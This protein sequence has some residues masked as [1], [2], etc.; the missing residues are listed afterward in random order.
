MHPQDL[1]AQ[2]HLVLI[3][4]LF[5]VGGPQ[6]LVHF[7]GPRCKQSCVRVSQRAAGRAHPQR[8]CRTTPT[9]RHGACW[10]ESVVSTLSISVMCSAS[11]RGAW[12]RER[13]IM[14]SSERLVPVHTRRRRR[15]EPALQEW[16]WEE[17][18]WPRRSPPFLQRKAQ[19]REAPWWPCDT[20]QQRHWDGRGRLALRGQ[21]EHRESCYCRPCEE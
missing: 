19:K 15:C 4:E 6:E 21:A 11:A 18:P 16:K 13:S 5:G 2:D 3:D 7:Y 9:A 14:Q 12:S 17:A 10:R 8:S 20:H 1:G